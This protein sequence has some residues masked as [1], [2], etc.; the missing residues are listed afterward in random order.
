MGKRLYCHSNEALPFW[1]AASLEFERCWELSGLVVIGGDGASWIDEGMSYFPKAV[2][3]QDG[4][5]L[6][7]WCRWAV[8]AKHGQ[9]I[10]TAIREG[11][12][13][14][15]Q[16]LL[17]TAPLASGPKAQQALGVVARQLKAG[18]DWRWQ[19]GQVVEGARGLGTMESQQDKTFANQMKKRGMSWTIKRAQSMGKVIQTVANG[20]WARWCWSS[21]LPTRHPVPSKPKMERKTQCQGVYEGTWLQVDVPALQGPHANRPWVQGLRSLVYPPYRLN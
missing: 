12:S 17:A 8:G 14:Q 16:H 1:E 21:T 2:R 13:Q 11:R 9:A 4:F 15:A 7:R 10:Y 5:H 6:A 20:E 19:V 18:V 3:Q